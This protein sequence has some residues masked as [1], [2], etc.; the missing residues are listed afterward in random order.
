MRKKDY[1]GLRFGRLFVVEVDKIK[2]NKH[3]TYWKCVCD[4]G[5]EKSVTTGHLTA[6]TV[7]S[8]GCLRKEQAIERFRQAAIDNIKHGKCD[9]HLYKVWDVMRQRCNNPNNPGYRWYGKKGVKVCEEW[10]EF[11]KFEKWAFENGY[12]YNSN[13]PRNLRLSIDRIDSNGDYCPQNCRWISIYENSA[14]ALKKGRENAKRTNG[15]T[16]TSRL[17]SMDSI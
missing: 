2:T 1:T 10:N 6:G 5:K 15:S 13:V 9:T 11:S 3:D 4:C 17:I 8:C 14:R 16:R 7:T 12:E